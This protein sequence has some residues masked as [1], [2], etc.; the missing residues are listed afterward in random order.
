MK[1]LTEEQNRERFKRNN[2]KGLGTK[3]KTK[4]IGM[5]LPPDLEEYVRNLPPGTRSDWLRSAVREKMERE[6]P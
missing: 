5:K 3:D 1:K 2:S 4:A 6:L